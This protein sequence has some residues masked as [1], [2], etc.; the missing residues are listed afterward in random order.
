MLAPSE[1]NQQN[2]KSTTLGALRL[3]PFPMSGKCGF[4]CYR[5][6]EFKC[7]RRCTYHSLCW[8]SVLTVVLMFVVFGVGTSLAMHNNPNPGHILVTNP[9]GHSLVPNPTINDYVQGYYRFILHQVPNDRPR[10]GR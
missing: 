10:D 3:L 5:S 4:K 7:E 2:S 9:A 6:C 8:C 1:D